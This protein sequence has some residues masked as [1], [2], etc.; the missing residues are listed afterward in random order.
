MVSLYC[1][2]GF[3]QNEIQTLL[4]TYDNQKQIG[5]NNFTAE[6][7]KEALTSGKYWISTEETETLFKFLDP[8]GTGHIS[9]KPFIELFNNERLFAYGQFGMVNNTVFYFALFEA[10][11]L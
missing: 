2:S 5:S 11:E 6:D 9:Y 3:R 8:F 4:K 1:Q 10:L 7:L